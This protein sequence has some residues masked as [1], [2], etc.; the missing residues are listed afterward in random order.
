MPCGHA[1]ICEKC[2]KKFDPKKCERCKQIILQIA[3]IE[4]KEHLHINLNV[5]QS[6]DE[7]EEFSSNI[8]NP[9]TNKN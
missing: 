3:I 2:Y 7:S 4:E 8:G 9:T 6:I 5:N 1:F